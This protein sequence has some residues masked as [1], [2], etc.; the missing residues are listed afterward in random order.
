MPYVTSSAIARIEYNELS[1]ELEVMF[2]SGRTY[3]Y[4]GVP[5][6]IYVAFISTSSKG[7]FFNDHIKDQYSR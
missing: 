7:Q 3:T 6:E 2:T 1:R 5:K 4:Y